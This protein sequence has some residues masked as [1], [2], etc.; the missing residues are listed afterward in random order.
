MNEV[1]DILEQLGLSSFERKAYLFLLEIGTATAFEISSKAGVPLGRVYTVMKQLYTKGLI[2]T[3]RLSNPKLYLLNDP[4]MALRNLVDGVVKGYLQD[5]KSIDAS[6][7]R[8]LESYDKLLTR[9]PQPMWDVYH[10][11]DVVYHKAIPRL[12]EGSK[13]EV[14]I[15]GQNLTEIMTPEFLV[16]FEK[17]LARGV[18]F[19]GIVQPRSKALFTKHSDLVDSVYGVARLANVVSN[20]WG[21]RFEVKKK[22]FEGITPFII[23]DK[24]KVAFF[25]ISPRNGKYLLTL[26]TNAKRVVGDYTETFQDL[27]VSSENADVLKLFANLLR[28]SN[29]D[30]EAY[31]TG[32][33]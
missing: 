4:M 8:F 13:E 16:E 33:Q 32:K 15:V 20:H 28:R 29:I 7:G 23:C 19:R 26:V 9:S 18:I 3:D 6:I 12:L 10:S 2:K 14:L 5:M 17:A 30:E 27:W 22:N 21:K 31:Q 11:E 24:L 1:A 25:I